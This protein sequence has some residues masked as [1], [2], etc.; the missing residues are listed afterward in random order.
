MESFYGGRSGAAFIIVQRFDGIDIPQPGDG[1]GVTNYTYTENEYATQPVIQPD[2]TTKMEFI[3]TTNAAGGNV[4]IDG[5]NDVYLIEKNS[6]NY[7]NYTWARQANNGDR[8]NDTSYSFPEI[9]ARGMV[10]CFRKGT[11]SASEVNYGEYVLID[12]ML[13]MHCQNNPD[14]GKVFRRG[15]DV[16][17]PL[18]GAEYIG[19]IV[20]PKGDSPEVDI[21]HYDEVIKRNPHSQKTYNPVDGDIVPGSYVVGSTRF[22]E[23]DIKYVYATVRDAHGNIEGCEIGFRLPTL[24]QDFEANSISPY[25]SRR[26]PGTSGFNSKYTDLIYEDP[27]QYQNDQWQ[28]PFFQKWQIDIPQGYHGINPEDIEVIH[29]YTMTPEYKA[30]HSTGVPVPGTIEIYDD[31]ECTSIY[32]I[33]DKDSPVKSYRIYGTEYEYIDSSKSGLYPDFDK[34]YNKYYMPNGV[35]YNADPSVISVMIQIDGG[36]KYVKKED[37]YMDI[38]RY[39]EVD[40]DD[41]E[42]GVSRYFYIGDYDTIQRVTISDDGTLTVFYSAKAQPKELEQIL[43]WID[44]KN[45]EG[46]TIDED[47]TVHVYYNTVHD[48]DSTDPYEKLDAQGRA[49]DHQDYKNV[50]DWVTEITLSKEG[51]FT[52]LYNNDTVK[53]GEDT[54]G[55]PIYGN[56]YETTLQWID[57][58]DF[59]YDGTVTFR[60]NTDTTRTGTPAYQFNNKIKFIA[61]DTTDPVTG[62]PILGVDIQTIN[63][64]GNW[65]GTGDQKVHVRFNNDGGIDHPIGVP[66]N[67]PIEYAIIQNKNEG[68]PRWT[69]DA[70][71]DAKNLN[72]HLIVYYS[73]PE[74]RKTLGKY[75]STTDN[76]WITYPS[77]KYMDPPYTDSTGATVQKPHVWTEWVDLGSVTGPAGGIHIIKEVKSLDELK[78]AAGKYI[79]PESLVDSASQLIL[80]DKAAGWA[81]TIEILNF[82]TSSAADPK[83]LKII[84]DGITPAANEINLSTVT[85]ITPGFTIG[86]YVRE[87]KESEY[88]FYDYEKKTWYQAR[89]NMEGGSG[90]ANPKNV[91]DKSVPIYDAAEGWIPDRLAGDAKELE[92]NGWWFA[93]DKGVFAE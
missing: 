56:K 13:N 85:A 44:T 58:V 64:Y 91:I 68:Y 24:V 63:P 19:Q 32:K 51:K 65:E 75:V 28:H 21:L 49:H 42:V 74:L 39:H 15:M 7:K 40:F 48:P 60:W 57:Y 18:A 77:A 46:I 70:T 29:T 50:L 2:G 61:D 71:E 27:A 22:Y 89:Y 45:S 30:D 86:D 3:L 87:T 37:C 66:L 11:K 34:I 26:I 76:E 20:G 90:I 25:D 23:D 88:V 84:A 81:C 92:V 10:Q 55:N 53:V 52:I 1:S 69:R 93:S 36:Y 4:E 16:L 80:G 59:N 6:E 33:I 62:E 12:T 78:D 67:Y 17:S 31:P 47:G 8:I 14:N 54:S 38:L 9:L 83:A 72:G 73:D 43:R 5:A 79:P 35:E 82:K 41:V